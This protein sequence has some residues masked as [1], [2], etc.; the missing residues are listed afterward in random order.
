[1]VAALMAAVV[2]CASLIS[3]KYGLILDLDDFHAFLGKPV[4][5][6]LTNVLLNL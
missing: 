1:M 6:L 2:C 4:F 5:I 3:G